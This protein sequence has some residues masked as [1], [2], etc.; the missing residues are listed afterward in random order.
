MR[1]KRRS[2]GVS[3]P[4]IRRAGQREI[5]LAISPAKA[6]P[7]LRLPVTRTR[8]VAPLGTISASLEVAMVAALSAT[9]CILARYIGMFAQQF[10]IRKRRRSR[11]A[12]IRKN[13]TSS[14]ETPSYGSFRKSSRDR[15]QKVR[16]ERA[17]HMFGPTGKPRRRPVV[18]RNNEHPL[19]GVLRCGVCNGHMRIAQ[20]SRNGGPRAACANAHQRGYLR[21]YAEL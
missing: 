7:R 17:I 20:S 12:A 2:C 21:A 11:S 9:S 15:A 3:S 19:A 14:L 5:S 1:A 18:P 4:S 8:L 6:C 13:A 16:S 10:S